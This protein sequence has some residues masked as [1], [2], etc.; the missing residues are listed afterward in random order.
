MIILIIGAVIRN[1]AKEEELHFKTYEWRIKPGVQ[2]LLIKE[3][4]LK[5]LIMIVAIFGPKE[6]YWPSILC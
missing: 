1:L 5:A 2:K 3:M 6:Q 4:S